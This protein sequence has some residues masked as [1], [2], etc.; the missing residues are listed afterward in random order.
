MNFNV[1]PY[2]AARALG[3][4]QDV[5]IG[6]RAVA[7]VVDEGD[8]G[9]EVVLV[10]GAAVEEDPKCVGPIGRSLILWRRPRNRTGEYEQYHAQGCDDAPHVSFRRSNGGMA[11]DQGRA[12]SPDG[13]RWS[14]TAASSA[15]LGLWRRVVE[16][17]RPPVHER[18]LYARPFLE[19]VAVGDDDVGDL[20]LLER[21][22]A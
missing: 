6:G 10:A 8:F 18:V 3:R 19:Q 21:S 5:Q 22:E 2:S 15:P 7:D 16:R 11:G 17:D 13:Q 20:A 9:A 14:L 1:Y 4:H 12:F